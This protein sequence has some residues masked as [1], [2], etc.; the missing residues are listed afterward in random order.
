MG[1][2]SPNL[3]V[4]HTHIKGDY[5]WTLLADLSYT[6]NDGTVYLIPTGFVT[7]LA[8]IPR[9][10]WPILAPFWSYAKAS[11]LHDYLLDSGYDPV[12]AT[13]MFRE[14]ME[15]TGVNK[16]QIF[17]I[18]WSVRIY[19]IFKP[20]FL[21]LRDIYKACKSSFSRPKN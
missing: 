7:D 18:Y 16:I 8:S 21:K 19:F 2:F 11:V 13:K 6:A 17:F 5:V 3:D 1:A 10:F 14:A 4:R 20:F 15:S 12:F 9:I